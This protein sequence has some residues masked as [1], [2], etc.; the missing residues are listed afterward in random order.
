MSSNDLVTLIAKRFIQRRDV[1][2]VQFESG[3]YIPDRELKYPKQ[4]APLGFKGRHLQAHLDGTAT[5]GHYL[6]DQNSKCRLFAFDIDLLPKGSY[7]TCPDVETEEEWE[8]Q[9][10]VVECNPREAWMDRRNKDARDWYK[11]QMGML[12]RKLTSVITGQLE[13]PCAAAYSGH[14][15]IHVYGFTG[16][17][18]AK[19]AREGA[20]LVL[21]ILGEFELLKGKHFFKHKNNDPFMGY[22]SFSIETFPKQD[23]LDGKD[24]GNLMRLPL[25][26]HLESKDP[27]FFLDLTT[28]PGVMKPHSDPTKLLESGDPYS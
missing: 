23:G 7:V 27:T 18:P 19:E 9:S 4:H 2:A 11:L 8:E 14:K 10:R 22:P 5:Y 25:G 24:L 1:K 26:R 21:D 12:A 28:P 16:P 20:L 13:L 17:V 15:G 6:L 3:A